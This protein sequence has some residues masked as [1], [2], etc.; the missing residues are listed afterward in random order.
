LDKQ[1]TA[2]ASV[3]ASTNIK[4]SVFR[5]QSCQLAVYGKSRRRE[6]GE[7]K[8]RL[9]KNIAQKLRRLSISRF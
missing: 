2:A 8:H 4:N 9:E 6:G 7:K 1:A 3:C 5:F